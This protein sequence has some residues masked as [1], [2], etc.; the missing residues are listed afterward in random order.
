[1][2]RSTAFAIVDM[3]RSSRVGIVDPRKTGLLYGS[4]RWYSSR[5]VE[6]VTCIL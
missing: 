5:F 6:L 3:A 2:S 1:M 4:G